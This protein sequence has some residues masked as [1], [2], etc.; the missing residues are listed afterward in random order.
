MILQGMAYLSAFQT[1]AKAYIHKDLLERR[2]R[3]DALTPL[4]SRP[5]EAASYSPILNF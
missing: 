3:T 1:V 4:S 5:N 2:R